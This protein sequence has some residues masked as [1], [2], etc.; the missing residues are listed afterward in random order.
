M[1]LMTLKQFERKS[2]ESLIR[3]ITKYL[4]KKSRKTLASLAYHITKGQ[5]PQLRVIKQKALPKDKTKSKKK[6]EKLSKAERKR[7]RKKLSGINKWR[8][9]NGMKR[10]VIK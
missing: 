6:P 7:R 1:K 3:Y 5:L 4:K 8:E 2:K 10:I 9:K